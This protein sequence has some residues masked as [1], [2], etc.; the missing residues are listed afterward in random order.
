MS[1]LVHEVKVLHGKSFLSGNFQIVSL[2][3][4]AGRP[5]LQI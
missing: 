2:A 3:G 1:K 5:K 4:P